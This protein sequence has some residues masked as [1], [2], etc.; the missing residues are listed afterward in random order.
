M[1]KAI[2]FVL[3]VMLLSMTVIMSAFA[4]PPAEW[5]T[6]RVTKNSTKITTSMPSVPGRA[7]Y[8]CKSTA[9]VRATFKRGPTMSDAGAIYTVENSKSVTSGVGQGTSPFSVTV[10]ARNNADIYMSN[11][12]SCGFCVYY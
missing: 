5:V 4:L 11:D 7:G 10:N 3:C 8:I 12:G 1:K 6:V 9:V 2:C